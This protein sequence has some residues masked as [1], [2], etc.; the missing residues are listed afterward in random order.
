MD[1]A[2]AGPGPGTRTKRT[3]VTATASMIAGE[4]VVVRDCNAG[5]AIGRGYL[6]ALAL[7]VAASAGA[8]VIAAIDLVRWELSQGT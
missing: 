8:A 5:P 1:L 3:R 7:V 4:K 2:G 6:V